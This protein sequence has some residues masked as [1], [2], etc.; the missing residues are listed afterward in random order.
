M[1]T[2]R[3]KIKGEVVAVTSDELIT[4]VPE[5]ETKLLKLKGEYI[6]LLKLFK[7]KTFQEI[8]SWFKLWSYNTYDLEFKQKAQE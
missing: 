6:P 3:T 5:L 8:K 4:E 2:Q 7:N 1:L